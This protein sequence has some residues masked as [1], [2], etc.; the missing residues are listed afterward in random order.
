MEVRPRARL[1][2]FHD[3]QNYDCASRIQSA[4]FKAVSASRIK[5]SISL[6]VISNMFSASCC[7]TISWKLIPQD[8][9]T[10]NQIT[11]MNISGQLLARVRAKR[12]GMMANSQHQVLGKLPMGQNSPR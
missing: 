6:D 3:L 7:G 9:G 5:V 12:V 8:Y 10:G 2:R 11:N 4:A 1:N